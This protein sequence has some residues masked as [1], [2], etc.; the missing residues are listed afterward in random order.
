MGICQIAKTITIVRPGRLRSRH[1][2]LRRQRKEG[3]AGG[4]STMRYFGR[5]R[6]EVRLLLSRAKGFL[7]VLLC[8]LLACSAPVSA[9]V[10]L[11]VRTLGELQRWRV[12]QAGEAYVGGWPEYHIQYKL[13]TA[14]WAE[15]EGAGPFDTVIIVPYTSELLW[16]ETRTA[17]ERAGTSNHTVW[18]TYEAVNRYPD[19]L[20]FQV[21]V[22][23]PLAA[24]DRGALHFVYRDSA[25]SFQHVTPSA[26]EPIYETNTDT[27]AGAT[28]E[29]VVQLP[30]FP[31]RLDWFSLHVWS[32]VSPE[33]VEA[34]WTF[35]SVD[36][37]RAVRFADPALELLVR[38]VAEL[39]YGEIEYDDV[40]WIRELSG[41]YYDI[42]ALD[43]IEQL[44]GLERLD[45]AHNAIRDVTPLA[46]LT[47]L[48]SLDLSDNLVES[49]APLAA[50][51][52][53]R[54][55]D[56][57]YNR[58]E[59][60]SP[61]SSLDG[62][63][64]LDVLGNRIRSL[65]G[66][67]GMTSLRALNIAA[68]PVEGLEP[69][70][71]LANLEHLVAWSLGIDDIAPLAGLSNLRFLD[72]SDNRIADLTPIAGLPNL[73]RLDAFR[74]R[75]AHIEPLADLPKLVRADVSVNAVQFLGG[76]LESESAPT[77]IAMGNPIIGTGLSEAA[78][79][80]VRGSLVELH[81][82]G[83]YSVRF[84]DLEDGWLSS[85]EI[86]FGDT[87][88]ASRTGFSF[89]PIGTHGQRVSEIQPFPMGEG[90]ARYMMIREYTGGWHCCYLVHV[91][92][93]DPE[94]RYVDT[95][96]GG[97]EH[98]EFVDLDGDGQ[99]E[100]RV[101]DWSFAY[102]RTA[103][104]TSP[105]P[106]VVLQFDGESFRLAPEHMRRAAPAPGEL[107]ALADEV[108]H[109]AFWEHYARERGALLGPPPKLW[110]VMLDLIY[111]GHW[112]LAFGFL[113]LAWPA[114]VPSKEAFTT[115]FLARLQRSRYW[116]EIVSGLYGGQTTS[117]GAASLPAMQQE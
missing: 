37:E 53:L 89:L 9:Q 63:E 58:I 30:A 116:P 32:S 25:G 14:F 87:L 90:L 18:S 62:L 76:W 52:N 68:N 92:Q 93:V 98:P 59:S 86:W 104:A 88:L 99:F 19:E 96:V 33:G 114:G 17:E 64:E 22:Y 97:H 112:D 54:S 110:A 50:L 31:E 60:L 80:A 55:L 75:I 13:A 36:P 45:L 15:G 41:A 2:L 113:D 39:P 21:F 35:R 42:A 8:I 10:V 66:V 85:V 73:E 28:V 16:I 11:P 94:L 107:A 109:D 67:E 43:G 49:V 108:R 115:A 70:S 79:A 101:K 38:D 47:N 77:V 51:T 40:S 105:A 61:L 117:A 3:I 72:L 12:D 27:P 91:F 111:G 34:S 84:Y 44:T 1:P 81:E 29:V 106:W 71:G 20:L 24:I 48:R 56:L 74:N 4:T 5:H 69:L 7:Y 100:V 6:R 82:V 26:H 57:S 23:G 65:H 95:V 102:W 46:A 83:P 103:F 78:L